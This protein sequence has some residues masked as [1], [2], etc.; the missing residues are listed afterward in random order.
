MTSSAENRNAPNPAPLVEGWRG[1]TV[2]SRHRGH[3]AA[4]EGDGRLVACAG[5][6]ETVTYL[7]SSGKPFQAI[8]LVT[9]G[10]GGRFRLDETE[11]AIAC[12]SHSG[13]DIHAETV[14]RMLEKIGLD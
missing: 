11:L 1:R 5:E 6:P 9:S 12:G 7:R 3:I 8:P 13:E 10:A 4:V 2:E 14:A